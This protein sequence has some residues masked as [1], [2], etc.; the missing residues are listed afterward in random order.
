MRKFMLFAALLSLLLLPVVAV[1]A[2]DEAEAEEETTEEAIPESVGTA[3]IRFAHLAND[4][5]E[6]DIYLDGVLRSNF[7]AVPFGTVSGWLTIPGG[8]VEVAVVP[9]GRSLERSAVVGPVTLQLDAG[10]NTTIAVIG[11][12]FS[13]EIEPV[14]ISEDY[15]DGEL[16]EFIARVTVFHAIPDAPIVDVLN[17]GELFL[18][19]LG[20]PGTITLIGGGTNDGYTTVDVPVGT[21]DLTVVP[22]GQTGP[23]VLDLTGTALEGGNHYFV[24]AAGTL[25]DPQVIVAVEPDR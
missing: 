13:T 17:D 21:Y 20:Y 5:E 10:T 15:E 24:A 19:R 3:E 2:Q 12:A 8:I 11:S 9:T 22:N 16:N 6:A 18:G 25:A 14:L 4:I 7:E 23:V 1:N